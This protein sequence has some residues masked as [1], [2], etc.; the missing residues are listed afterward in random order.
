[1]EA[2][3]VGDVFAGDADVSAGTVWLCATNHGKRKTMLSRFTAI[4][5]VD[6]PKKF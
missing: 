6:L 4:V 2:L 3:P 1:M 5:I